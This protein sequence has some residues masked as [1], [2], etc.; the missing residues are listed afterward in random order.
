[1]GYAA[2]RLGSPWGDEEVW[3]NPGQAALHNYHLYEGPEGWHKQVR[4]KDRI[5]GAEP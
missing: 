4:S 3:F 2:G 1:M 5:G